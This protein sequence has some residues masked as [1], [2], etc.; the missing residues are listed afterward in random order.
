M[1][2]LSCYLIIFIA[3]VDLTYMIHFKVKFSDSH[4][5]SLTYTKLKNKNVK[6]ISQSGD[7]IG[8]EPDE[9][10]SPAALMTILKAREGYVSLDIIE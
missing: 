5:A 1:V 4:Y 6:W 3:C 7:R 9:N 8:I 10:S 2:I